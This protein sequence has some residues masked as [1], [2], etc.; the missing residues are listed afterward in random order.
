MRSNMNDNG[1]FRVLARAADAHRLNQA[2]SETPFDGFKFKP[3]EVIS[4]LTAKY[5][6]PD[7]HEWPGY[8]FV[9]YDGKVVKGTWKAKYWMSDK[10]K[11]ELIL[12]SGDNKQFSCSG[13]KCEVFYTLKSEWEKVLN[14]V[15]Q[16]QDSERSQKEKSKNKALNGL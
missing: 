9:S 7:E 14:A 1:C 16:T 10:V 8:P 3:E 6:T 13:A 4:S 15:A 2:F 11:I 5:G 12:F